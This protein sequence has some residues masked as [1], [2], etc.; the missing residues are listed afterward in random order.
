[1]MAFDTQLAKQSPL[2]SKFRHSTRWNLR[3]NNLLRLHLLSRLGRSGARLASGHL[4]PTSSACT[5]QLHR[6]LVS[7]HLSGPSSSPSR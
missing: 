4:D 3:S 6:L 5:P 2:H 1:M 7:F